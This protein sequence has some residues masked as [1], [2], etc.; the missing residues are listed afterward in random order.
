[1]SAS[2][3]KWATPLTAATFLVTAVTGILLYLHAGGSLSRD[4]HIWI[5]FAVT[6]VLVLHIFINWRPFRSYLKR[7]LPLSILVLGVVATVA[8]SVSF[9]TAAR[10]PQVNP[11]ML[12]NAM[13]GARL[14]T[15]AELAGMSTE[16]YLARLQAAG[17]D[18][19]TGQDT[20]ASLGQGDRAASTTAL[21]LAFGGARP[22]E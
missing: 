20:I 14:E 2:L 4:A 3:R 21:A 11:G 9:G 22:A 7:P 5:G 6:A 16:A 19:A 1:M 17:F 12:F 13:N 8:S 10:G 18:G 15:V